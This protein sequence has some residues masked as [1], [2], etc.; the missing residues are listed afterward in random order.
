MPTNI[1]DNCV[2]SDGIARVSEADA[3]RLSR[4][5]LQVGDIV[6]SRRGDVERRALVR[7][8][9][10]GWLCGTGSLRVRVG[11]AANSTWLSYYLGD[12]NVRAWIVQHS[13]GATMANLNSSILSDL[14]LLLP[15]RT[16]QDAI[17]D[18]LSAFDDK[19][20][21]NRRMNLTLYTLMT[22]IWRSVK[23]ECSCDQV[24][25][26][27]LA[28]YVNG[29]AFTKGADGSG[30]P[31]IRIRELNSG[32]TR[33]TPRSSRVVPANQMATAGDLLFSWSASLD[34]YRWFG[35][36]SLINQHIF[37]VF[38]RTGYP[39]WLVYLALCEAMPFFQSVARD[40][41]TTMGHIQRHHLNEATVEVPIG[42][43]PELDEAI[44]GMYDLAGENLRQ[45]QTLIPSR[46]ALLVKLISGELRHDLGADAA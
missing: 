27:G 19:L 2:V 22:A 33:A 10:E 35:Q 40:K 7:E 34:V 24:S 3:D 46:D 15:P 23:R 41:A 17:A 28:E 25:L 31:I 6:Y 21:A 44:G 12:P 36:D 20:A 32:V 45:E 13:V 11:D 4:H 29:G 39:Q 1:G 8:A 26:S 42:M 37:K 16:E 14:P 30:H 5:R 43:A 38:P 9:E 18:T